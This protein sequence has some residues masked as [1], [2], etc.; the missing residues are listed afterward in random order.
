M[1]YILNFV[2]EKMPW[3]VIVFNPEM[4]V[5]YSNKTAEKFF[6]RYKAPEELPSI[7]RRIFDAIETSRVKELFP[8]EINLHKEL[9]GSESKWIFKFFFSEGA[10][11]FVGIFIIEGAV[12]YTMNLN[13]IRIRFG[14]TRRE[15]DV[16][17][18][19]LDGR[20][21]A[22]IAEDLEITEQTVKDHL[23]NVYMKIGAK[24]RFELV[25]SLDD[26][27]QS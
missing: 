17:G 2:L 8:G 16:L 13:R 14:L 12:S 23:S 1:D 5:I 11:P 9:E 10:E 18:C 4:K 15:T 19:L 27:R 6:R 26:L 3:G 21:N 7:S 25:R 20:K 22:E 24:N